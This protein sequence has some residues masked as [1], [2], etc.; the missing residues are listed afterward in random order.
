MCWA[1]VDKAAGEL[2]CMQRIYI[3]IYIPFHNTA[4]I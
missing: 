3:Y 4:S 2:S 1:E